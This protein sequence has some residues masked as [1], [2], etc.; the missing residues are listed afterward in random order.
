MEREGLWQVVPD[1]ASQGVETWVAILLRSTRLP[2]MN[3]LKLQQSE[4]HWCLANN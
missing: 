3:I 2:N 4:T 1:R